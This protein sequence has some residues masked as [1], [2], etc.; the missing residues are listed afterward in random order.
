MTKF[1]SIILATAA[2]L[3]LAMSA[4]LTLFVVN[5]GGRN[6]A[7]DQKQVASLLGE[8]AEKIGPEA[9][10]ALGDTHHYMGVQSTSDPLWLTNYELIYSHPE[11]QVPWLPLLGNHEYRGN[12][13]AVIDYSNVSRRWQMPDRYYTHTFSK[14]G[15][16][17]RLVMIDTAPLIDKYRTERDEYPDVAAQ[18]M[19]RQLQWVDSVLG[20]ATEDWIIVAGHHPVRGYTPKAKSERTDLQKRLEPIFDRHRVDLVIGGHIHNFQHLRHNGRDYVVN[21]SASQTRKSEQ[22]P[23]TVFTQGVTGFS[24]ISATPQAL[25]LNMTDSNGKTIHSIVIPAK[26]KK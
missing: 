9:V 15:T 4:Q 19:E 16:S 26:A 5:D 12:S 21:G 1:K 17:V 25:T 7:Y 6:G 10:L 20:A 13:Q 14:D 11:L 22:G 18:N 3:P 24:V 8:M 23:E 2:F